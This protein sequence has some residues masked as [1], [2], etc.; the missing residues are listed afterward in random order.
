MRQNDEQRDGR[1]EGKTATILF[2]PLPGIHAQSTSCALRGRPHPLPWPPHLQPPSL[3]EWNPGRQ[4]S[5]FQPVT[6]GLQTQAPEASHWRCREP[7]GGRAQG[8]GGPPP[9]EKG[10]GPGGGACY[11]LGGSHRA[12]TASKGSSDRSPPGSAR[13]VARPCGP[14]SGGSARRGPCCGRAPGRR[15]TP[16]SGHCSCRLWAGG[17]GRRVSGRRPAVGEAG[18]ISLLVMKEQAAPGRSRMSAGPA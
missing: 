6:V 9:S 17:R 2:L 13:S 7:G 10:A 1:K 18:P 8:S 12:G 3:S 11:L 4:R 5:H 14:G 15:R 16:P